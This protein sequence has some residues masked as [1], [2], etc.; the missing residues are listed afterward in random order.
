MGMPKGENV[1]IDEVVR[2]IE[3][4]EYRIPRFQRD[5]VWE[6]KKSAALIDSIFRGYPIGSII[7]WE[8]KNK[9]TC[10][11]K[12]D[13]GGIKIPGKDTG[14][15]T[16]YIIDGQQ[17]LTSLFMAV[18]GLTTGKG[19]DF[20]SICVSLI[21]TGNEQIVYDSLP[22]DANLDDYVSL[23]DLFNHD[24]EGK[25]SEQRRKYHQILLQYT[26]SVIKIDDDQLGLDQVVEI[27]ERLNLG[28]KK[29]NMFSIVSARCYSP[30]TDEDD[31]FDL[32]KKLADLN[33]SL[34]DKK[35]GEI[36]DSTF[37]QVIS[38]CVIGKVQK[39]EILK[40]LKEQHVRENYDKI[41]KA[42]L[43]AIQHLKGKA[44]GVAICDLLP[45]ERLLVPF[46]YFHF[47][48]GKKSITVNQEKYLRDYFWRCI[49]LKRYNNAA[50]ANMDND[51]QRINTILKGKK[52]DQIGVVLSPKSIFENGKFTLSSSY[53]LGM[54][55]LMAQNNP[56][57]FAEGRVIELT[58]TAISKGSKKQYHHFFPK[59]SDVILRNSDYKRIVNNV[60]N[61][62]FLD[63][64]TNNHIKNLNP[65]K[66]LKKFSKQNSKMTSIL[67]SHYISKNGFGL[68]KDEFYDFLNARSYMLYLKL[69]SHLVIDKKH[70]TI[71]DELPFN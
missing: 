12:K 40:N 3:N 71:I 13:L 70:D 59:Q 19:Q 5:F 57:S 37:L 49:L 46:A 4:G 10:V 29:L 47:K 21:A 15:Y 42:L 20:S 24:T 41:E 62:V 30:E 35:Y 48:R 26:I 58:D 6:I 32:T 23:V 7:V 1:T 31:G 53:V 38:A 51:L 45:Y 44:Y 61:I 18:K 14:R 39:S 67:K 16:S 64:T 54:L 28:G 56:Q 27:F 65:S 50:D 68:E 25:H 52:P 9:L 11:D 34:K 36:G 60:V 2:Y 17:R 8:T 43:E 69:K 66:Y 55:C 63:S 22:K 33:K